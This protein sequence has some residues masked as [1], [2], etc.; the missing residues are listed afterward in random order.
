LK[1][2][3]AEKGPAGLYV[4]D[5]VDAG[6]SGAIAEVIGRAIAD[7]ARH[8]QVLCITHLPQIAALADHHFVVGKTESR[9]RTTSSVKKLT[10][11]ERIEEI[12]R[13]IG[14]VKIGEAAR[15]AAHELLTAS[16]IPDGGVGAQGV[17]RAAAKK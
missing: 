6:V 4:F 1:R 14:G 5:E 13:M 7:V 16:S 17:L 8:R 11:A 9:G 12:A 10:D 3:L 15:R 2:V